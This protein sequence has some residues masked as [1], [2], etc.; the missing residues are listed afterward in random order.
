MCRCLSG[1]SSCRVTESICY[2]SLPD[3]H[4]LRVPQQVT[5]TWAFGLQMYSCRVVFCV[6]CCNNEKSWKGS[7]GSWGISHVS[8]SWDKMFTEFFAITWLKSGIRLRKCKTGTNDIWYREW[9]R[10][11]QAKDVR[12]TP[13]ADTVPMRHK[14]S[15]IKA[16]TGP[17]CCYLPLQRQ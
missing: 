13:S 14:R 4:W 15:L 12:E 10:K 17:I 8:M 3:P 11:F 5:N 6:L 16:K 7:M 9:G 1:L 2:L